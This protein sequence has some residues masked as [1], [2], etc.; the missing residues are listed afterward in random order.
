VGANPDIGAWMIVLQHGQIMLAPDR[1]KDLE[2]RCDPGE[3]F[4]CVLAERLHLLTAIR[5][6][7]FRFEPMI[8]ARQVR[9][10]RLPGSR[11]VGHRIRGGR[12]CA[13]GLSTLH[14]H[15]TAPGGQI[16]ELSLERFELTLQLL[17]LATEL[18]A[19]ERVDLRLEPLNLDITIGKRATSLQQQRL[20][21]FDIVW[22]FGAV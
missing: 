13:E 18:H 16:V 4:E 7:R 17:G 5:A 6:T 9:E 22:K 12:F 10:K 2:R 11:F 8:L 21:E 14:I 19:P 3:L 15:N 20:Q 1:A